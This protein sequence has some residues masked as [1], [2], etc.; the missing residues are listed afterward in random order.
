[1]RGR[2]V[3]AEYVWGVCCCAGCEFGGVLGVVEEVAGEG[4]GNWVLFVVQR[5]HCYQNY[6]VYLTLDMNL[7]RNR[8]HRY[9]NVYLLDVAVVN[10][11]V[12]LN[13][14]EI[15]RK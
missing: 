13:Y 8:Y 1:M 15:G 3:L 10:L 9:E 11:L 6:W 14:T 2:G 7:V 4:L 5:L 12:W